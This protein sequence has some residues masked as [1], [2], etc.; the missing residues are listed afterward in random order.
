MLKNKRT[1]KIV[2][3]VTL[4]LILLVFGV[5]ISMNLVSNTA[6][7]AP[8]RYAEALDKSWLFYEAQRSGNTNDSNYNTRVTWRVPSACRSHACAG[9]RAGKGEHEPSHG[10]QHERQGRRHRDVRLQRHR[11]Q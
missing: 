8:F 11:S 3:R 10:T 7:A 6:A 1:Q 2:T 5:F 9:R 4:L